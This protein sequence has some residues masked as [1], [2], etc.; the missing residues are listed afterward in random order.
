MFMISQIYFVNA[1]NACVNFDNK[2]FLN[3][4]ALILQFNKRLYLFIRLMCRTI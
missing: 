1:Y 2:R 3:V 4:N